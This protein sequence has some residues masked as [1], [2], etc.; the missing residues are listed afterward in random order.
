MTALEEQLT[1]A[2][3]DV[4]TDG[5]EMSLGEVVSLYKNSELIINPNFQRLFRW[6][7]GRKTRFIESLLLGIPIPPIFVFQQDD[8]VWELV[9]GLQRTSTILEFM[10]ELKADDGG[11]RPASELIATRLLPAL[12]GV[13]WRATADP[14][15][16]PAQRLDL[17]R[18]RIRVEILKRESHQSAKF[19]LF[20]RLNT[21]GSP[22]SEQE[23]RNCTMVMINP[24]FYSW[25][26]D[27]AGYGDFSKAVAVTDNAQDRQA[28]VEL[29]LRF[30]AFLYVPYQKGIDVHEYLDDAAIA[31]ATDRNLDRDELQEVFQETFRLIQGAFDGRAFRRWDGARFSGQFLQSVYEVVAIGVARNIE[32]YRGMEEAGAKNLIVR[33]SQELWGHQTFERYSGAGVRGTDR[34]ANLLPMAKGFMEP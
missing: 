2:R 17:R 18:A 14:C 19:E 34:L 8:G 27:L 29:A 6:D 20:Q 32:A 26:Q 16:T 22:L 10:G 28:Q 1:A 12:N 4:I 33:R 30:L 24:S 21:G 25:L 5:Y 13:T 15:L 11:C 31:L 3:R 7:I 23:V 9:D